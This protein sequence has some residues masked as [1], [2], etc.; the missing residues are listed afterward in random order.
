[1]HA[2]WARCALSFYTTGPIPVTH[3]IFNFL[4]AAVK[5]NLFRWGI[6]NRLA[7]ILGIAGSIVTPAW[8]QSD[9]YPSRPITLIV[10]SEPGGAT[11]VVARILQERLRVEL[12]TSHPIVI[13]N[14]YAAGGVAGASLVAKAKPDGYTLLV[15]GAGPIIFSPLLSSAV[16]YDPQKDFQYVALLS[17]LPSLAAVKKQLAASSL[18][19]LVALA[20][21]KPGRLTY[22]SSGMGTPS[23]L[24]GELFKQIAGVEILHVP[25]RG[26]RQV[27][28]AML[29]GEVDLSFSP[30]SATLPLVR[31]GKLRALAVT[32]N[33]RLRDAPEVPTSSEAGMPR[34]RILGWFGLMAPAG[35]PN[36][37]VTKLHAA[38]ARALSDRTVVEALR[39]SGNTEAH[40]ISPDDF[41][42]MVASE[43]AR[44]KQV[45][46]S[47][48]IK[49]E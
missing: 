27:A 49:L 32:S 6:A 15:T 33:Q 23:N 47:A 45:I 10:N 48:V 7:W 20:R 36:D 37:F 21:A 44:W 2:P 43:R 35:T 41:G 11:D 25:Y 38:V 42:S 34:L 31:D 22:G 26:S 40:D 18:E 13:Q 5:F 16:T 3:P 39:R 4:G 17:T 1:M 19:D 28:T 14:S 30:P 8:S 12:K 46:Q 9:E 24:A 29:S